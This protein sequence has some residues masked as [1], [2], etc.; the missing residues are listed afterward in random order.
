VNAEHR[1]YLEAIATS[2]DPA[3]KPSDRIRAIELLNEA[4]PEG[5][6]V[7]RAEITQLPESE[8]DNWFDLLASGVVHDLD[9]EA[10]RRRYPTLTVA[11]QHRVDAE[12]RKARLA[13]EQARRQPAAPEP[14]KVADRGEEPSGVAEPAS[15]PEEAPEADAQDMAGGYASGPD[16]DGMK[17]GA[18]QLE[19][20]WSDS[21]ARPRRRVRRLPSG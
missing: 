13:D 16:E 9:D 6:D 14:V 4:D 19:R 2:H 21:P 20:G 5:A 8:V 11:M 3:V 17:L 7:V 1:S 15:A 18:W 10:M 12:V